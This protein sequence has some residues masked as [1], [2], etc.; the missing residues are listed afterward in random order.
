MYKKLQSKFCHVRQP[1]NNQNS[2]WWTCG[3][4]YHFYRISANNAACYVVLFYLSWSYLCQICQ[5]WVRRK[6]RG[7]AKKWNIG[8]WGSEPTKWNHSVVILHCPSSDCNQHGWEYLSFHSYPLKL[9]AVR[10]CSVRDMCDKVIWCCPSL[11][12]VL[13]TSVGIPISR[14]LMKM[15]R[16]SWLSIT[17]W[18]DSWNLIRYEDS[19]LSKAHAH[20]I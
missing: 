4:I 5:I 19:T 2:S 1:T 12:C 7:A 18:L 11:A 8:N 16:L 15:V 10:A 9:R 3:T 20:T 14:P 13:S 6:Y 17:F